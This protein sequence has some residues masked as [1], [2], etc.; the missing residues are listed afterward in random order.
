MLHLK[1]ELLEVHHK[2]K[3]SSEKVRVISVWD[4]FLYQVWYA[5]Q[6]IFNVL[7]VGDF[8]FGFFEV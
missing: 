4:L 8:G 2:I 5:L 3:L 7:E 6:F 1:S